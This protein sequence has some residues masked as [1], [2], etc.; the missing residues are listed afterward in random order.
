LSTTF[1]TGMTGI[2]YKIFI[3]G[4]FQ[5]QC[6]FSSLPHFRHFLLKIWAIFNRCCDF[7]TK[8]ETTE[9]NLGIVNNFS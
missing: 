9:A 3:H 4:C 7:Q 8:K 6:F 1:L 5:G 2:F